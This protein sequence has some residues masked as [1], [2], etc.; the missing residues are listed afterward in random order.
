MMTTTATAPYRPLSPEQRRRLGAKLAAMPPGPAQQ[1]A[2]DLAVKLYG[3][4]PKT[5]VAAEQKK[6]NQRRFQPYRFNPESYLT[7][8]LGWEPWSGLDETHPG[9][10]QV[11]D[12]IVLAVRQQLEKREFEHGNL[13]QAELK[14]W[15]PGDPIQNWIR[16]ESGNGIGKTKML[17]G[18]VNWAVDCFKSI[19]YTFHTTAKQDELTTW[20]E[21]A[22]DRRGKGLPGRIL[23]TKIDIDDDRFA[24]SRSTADTKGS[25]EEK[26]KGQHAEFLFFCVDEADGVEDYVFDALETMESGG[27]SIIL[28]CANP[29]SRKSRFFRL[30]KHSYVKTF[31][32]SSLWHPNVVQGRDVIPGAVR[33]DFVEKKIETK[34]KV[35]SVP[36]PTKFT[37]DL[38]YDISPGGILR[39]AGT[40]F[41]PEPEF[42]WTVLGNPPPNSLDKTV[43]SSGVYE[44]ACKRIPLGDDP[45]TAWVG[46]DCARDGKD[47][48]T[49]YIYWQD[50]AWRSCELAQQ[51]TNSYVDVIKTECLKLKEK[52]VT[53]LHIRVDAGY[54]SGVIDA[55]RIDSDLME[56]FEEFIVFEVHFGSKAYNTRDYDN[57][58]TEMYYEAA[59]TL[60]G[61]T[62]LAPPEA[63]EIDLTERQFKFINRAGKTKKIL[64]PKE[65]FEKRNKRSP[66]DGDG[67]VLAIAPDYCFQRVTIDV[68]SAGSARTAT[69]NKT[70]VIDDLAKMLGLRKA[71][72]DVPEPSGRV[73]ITG[74]PKTGKTTLAA[75][76][77]GGRSTDDVMSLGWSEASERVSLWLDQPGPWIY[78]GVAIP[79]AL[80]KW[81]KR[82]PGKRP[83]IDKLIIL[84][85]PRQD[86]DPA[87][88]AM[89]K[90]LDT[91]LAEIMPWLIGYVT[92]EEVD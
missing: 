47:N 85:N 68:M 7:E 88:A 72:V 45:S 78:E 28:M 36:D 41:E 6:A 87:A 62:L 48:G 21:I 11:F 57:V 37:F 44:A 46:V 84:K 34:C 69:V 19:V 49:V 64:E 60:K 59:E 29:R 1:A 20:K 82:N 25:G 73:V 81:R 22:K 50:V 39:P 58:A 14:F 56:G 30:K 32:I 35:V 3:P 10:R 42:M 71:A 75:K 83:P 31:R 53:T 76:M 65:D 27:I 61:I 66:D 40:I 80:R 12:A 43:I 51:D 18:Y 5:A 2:V 23:N 4:A 74:W 54:G 17:S 92:I 67:L 8:F 26:I 90:A 63:L 9:Q 79:R 33:R 13:T 70:A 16:V 38:P 91:V 52:G 77:G 24:V 15:Q 55:L 89:G 86:L